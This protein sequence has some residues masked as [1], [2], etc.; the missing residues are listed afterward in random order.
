MQRLVDDLMQLTRLESGLLKL[1]RH[2]LALRPFVGS[3]IDRLN[4]ARA[5]GAIPPIENLVP[6]DMPQ[7]DVD[8]DQIERAL[9][10]L[11]DNALQYTPPSG[12]V[13]VTAE[14][15][16]DTWVAIGVTDT[17]AGIPSEDLP[18]IFERF[19]RSDKSRERTQGHSGLG[20]AIV[21]EI[22]EAHGGVVSVDSRPGQGTTFRL[23][24]PVAIAQN[25]Y[26]A[27]HSS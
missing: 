14:T 16:G 4:R 3:L 11:L 8:P 26:L 15:V 2:P 22:V 5:D 19:Y 7:V 18:R 24:L 27:A 20:L 12:S 23:T 17:G 21:R 1:D 10:N 25:S 13:S 9:R 6:P